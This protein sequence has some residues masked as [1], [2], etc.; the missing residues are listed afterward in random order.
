VGFVAFCALRDEAR[1]A[2]FPT[3]EDIMT[4]SR[5]RSLVSLAAAL[6]VTLTLG[7]CIAPPS[8]LASEAIATSD[9]AQLAFRF[10]NQARDNV[11]VYLIGAKREWLLGRVAPGARATLR[12]PDDALAENPG[13]MR[14][15]VLAGPHMTL[16]AAAESGAAISMDQPAE[17]IVSQRWTFSKTLEKGQLTALGLPRGR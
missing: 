6:T 5:I 11:N 4:T 3:L 7:G 2:P 14:L 12:I 16:R 1:N 9:G 10:D 17:A 13:F 15:A 8:Q